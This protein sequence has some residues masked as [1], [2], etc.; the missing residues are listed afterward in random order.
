[1]KKKEKEERLAAQIKSCSTIFFIPT[2]LPDF[3]FPTTET[4]Q[5]CLESANDNLGRCQITGN[6]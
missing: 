5:K 4:N 3:E 6:G 1:M 2:G